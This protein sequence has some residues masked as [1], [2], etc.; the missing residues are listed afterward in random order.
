MLRLHPLPRVTPRTAAAL[1]LLTLEFFFG[2]NRDIGFL[3]VWFE[4]RLPSR[5]C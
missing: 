4:T 3:W 1:T 5:T 2:T